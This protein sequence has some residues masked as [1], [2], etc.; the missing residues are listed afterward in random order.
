MGADEAPNGLGQLVTPAIPGEQ[1]GPGPFLGGVSGEGLKGW[2]YFSRFL[3]TLGGQTHSG[4]RISGGLGI[5]AAV[6]EIPA[7]LLVPLTPGVS[8][9]W[10]VPWLCTPKAI[11]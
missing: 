8:P 7:M 1:P 2:D 9:R 11:G 10:T 5:P 3:E 4:V 6:R